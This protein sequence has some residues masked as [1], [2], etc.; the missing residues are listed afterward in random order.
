MSLGRFGPDR[1]SKSSDVLDEMSP[2]Q[3]A[4]Y[5]PEQL[6]ILTAQ[7]ENVR[8]SSTLHRNVKPVK[9]G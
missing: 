6:A 7:R 1:W 9:V 4:S 3:K 8:S 2:A 5:T